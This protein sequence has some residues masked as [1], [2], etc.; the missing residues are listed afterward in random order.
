MVAQGTE[1]PMGSRCGV[2][3]VV[4]VGVEVGFEVGAELGGGGVVEAAVLGV[5]RGGGGWLVCGRRLVLREGRVL[6][7]RQK[8]GG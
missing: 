6:G 5:V 4:V 8:A 3:V 7:C 2:V 1:R